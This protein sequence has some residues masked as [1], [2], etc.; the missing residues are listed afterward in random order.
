MRLDSYL[1]EKG[2][3]ATRAK[4]SQAIK[5]GEV[6]VN[7]IKII[8]PSHEISGEPDIKIEA[9]KTFV[10]LGGYKL[11]K[12]IADFEIYV[13]GLVFADI[14]ASTGGFTDVLLQRG[15]KRVYCVDVGENLLD[16]KIAEDERVI[17]MDNR[18]A[19]YLTREDF[20]DELDGLVVDCSFISIKLLL[21]VLKGLI[22][23][24]GFIIALIKPQFE[25]SKKEKSKSGIL[26]GKDKQLDVLISVITF[27]REQNLTVGNLTYAPVAKKKNVE[28]LVLLSRAGENINDERIAETVE[29]AYSERGKL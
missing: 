12:A 25:S 9:P 7:G 1:V 10:S 11:D 8:K 17:V 19:R 22:K 29:R 5:R 4:S 18:N 2:F 28:Y 20:S 6:S 26:L 21:P 3:Y 14:G 15:A 23:N 27:C 24:N 13:N 16:K